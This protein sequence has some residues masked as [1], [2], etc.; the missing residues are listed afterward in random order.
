MICEKCVHKDVC[1]HK[2]GF[3]NF[4][5]KIEDFVAPNTKDNFEVEV[6]CKHYYE[7]K[8]IIRGFDAPDFNKDLIYPWQN[9][10][11]YSSQD[12]ITENPCLN[13][14]IYKDA[15]LRPG[16]PNDACSFCSKNPYKS[17]CTGTGG[18][19]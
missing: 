10:V 9:P 2:E 16:V 4:T 18:N 6:K 5:H 8:P 19:T 11:I 13:C 12:N 17:T 1:I 3:N 14:S 7:D 15:L